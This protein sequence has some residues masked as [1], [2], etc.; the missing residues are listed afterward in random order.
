MSMT[1]SR[2]DR[3]DG[4]LAADWVDRIVSDEIITSIEQRGITDPEASDRARGLF[5]FRLGLTWRMRETAF[6]GM[7]EGDINAGKARDNV[8]GAI[9]D[10][11]SYLRSENGHLIHSDALVNELSDVAT[12]LEYDPDFQENARDEFHERECRAAGLALGM[13]KFDTLS[14]QVRRLSERTIIT[15]L[16][17]NITRHDEVTDEKLREIVDSTIFLS[18]GIESHIQK[19]KQK[20][21]RLKN[22]AREENMDSQEYLNRREDLDVAFLKRVT[23][24]V[25]GAE[26]AG[27][28]VAKSFDSRIPSLMDTVQ[29]HAE[30]EAMQIAQKEGYE[31]DGSG[32]MKRSNVIPESGPSSKSGPGM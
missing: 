23:S 3:K 9:H 28:S 22:A 15:A 14:A 13:D 2:F 21:D 29:I 27:N 17:R 20:E 7:S 18:G 10:S 31:L 30:R 16:D 6:S 12:G 8:I 24:L 11:I 19:A 32:E 1:N 26:M 4:N 5:H 25:R